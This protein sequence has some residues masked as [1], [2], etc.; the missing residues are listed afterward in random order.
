MDIQVR[1]AETSD[2]RAAIYRLRYELYVEGQHLFSQEA[3]HESLTLQD[4]EDRGSRLLFAEVAGDVM[5]TLRVSWGGD[6]EF[7]PQTKRT[8]DIE[9]FLGVLRPEQIAVFSRLVV[10][11]ECR[12][13]LVPLQLVIAA[14]EF[15]TEHGVELGFCDCEPHLVGLYCALGFRPYRSLYNHPSNGVLVPLVIVAADLPYLE[16][17]ASPLSGVLAERDVPCEVL[18]KIEPLLTDPNSIKIADRGDGRFWRDIEEWCADWLRRQQ[19]GL[20]REGGLLAEIDPSQRRALLADGCILECGPGAALI[21]KGH[22][23]RT[24]YF[25]LE[26][27][28][29]VCDGERVLATLKEGEIVGEV[30][31][32]LPMRR[33]AD[34][35]VARRCRVLALNNATLRRILESGAPVGSRF[36]LAVSRALARKLAGSTA[37]WASCPA[38]DDLEGLRR[39]VALRCVDEGGLTFSAASAMGGSGGEID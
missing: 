27:A 33:T 4:D 38:H 24:I 22:V 3:D 18:Q 25:I 1:T 28:L 8:Y 13:G 5:G 10:R 37:N 9:R 23:S 12:G 34:V 32:L 26:G 31:F 35:R 15:A 16:S 36:L 17:V 6:A 2:E 14:A 19:P 11:P 30:A 20:E 21:C 7:S 29:D 39:L